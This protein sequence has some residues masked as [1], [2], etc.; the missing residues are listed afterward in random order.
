MVRLVLEGTDVA[1]GGVKAGEQVRVL[2]E[3]LLL[4]I[5]DPGEDSHHSLLAF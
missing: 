1:W 4:G 3:G 5:T 2:S